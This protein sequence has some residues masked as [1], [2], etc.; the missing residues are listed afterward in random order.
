MFAYMMLSLRT[1][2]G[3]FTFDSYQADE[4]KQVTWLVWL[5]LMIV[6]NI[7]FMNFIIAVIGDSYQSSMSKK[8]SQTYRLKVPFIV[9]IEKQLSSKESIDQVKEQWKNSIQN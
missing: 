3:D 4:M 1:A 8:V 2:I 6:G 5:T 7:V 9:E